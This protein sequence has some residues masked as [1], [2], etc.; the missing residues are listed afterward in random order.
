VKI[1]ES[2]GLIGCGNMGSAL[3]RC[4]IDQRVVRSRQV[5]VFDPIRSQS[6]KLAQ[7]CGVHVSKDNAALI[8]RSQIVILAIKPQTLK[9]VSKALKP[10]L[11][12]K[13][14][15]SILAGTPLQKL[16]A[17]LGGF[18]QL[19]RAMPNL[20]AL[21]G[22]SMTAI[23]GERKALKRAQAIFQGCGAV[24]QVPEKHFDL[25][26]AVSGS[27]PAYFFLLMERLSAFARQRGLTPKHSD[28]LA[29]QT[30]LGASQL[31]KSS[32]DSPA[33]LRR[34]VT[35]E[36]GTTAAALRILS[37]RQ[38]NILWNRALNRA[39]KRAREMSHF[40]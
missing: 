4:L 38:M 14:V 13:V 34:K 7:Q 24:I 36:K 32:V 40:S 8:K 22:Q 17:S 25:V 10:H 6:N 21:V 12:K 26:T 15:I 2:I 37:G 31:A 20:G 1:K 29:I 5:S 3:V 35:S 39:L 16:K 27:G 11:R 19:V 28:L 9:Q 33:V 23:A 18:C 30:A